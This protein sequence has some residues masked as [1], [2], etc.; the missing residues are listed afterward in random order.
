MS[1]KQAIQ[2]S[3]APA[4]IG[5]YS[6]AIRSGSLLFCSGQIPL[7]PTTMEIVSQDVADQAH[8]VFLNLSAVAESAG[9]SLDAA[10][11]LTIFL[12]DLEDFAVVNE[13]M[14][15]YFKQPYPARA[16]IQVSALPKAAQ[17]EIEAIL[18]L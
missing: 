11:K 4:A 3:N 15:K 6:Q 7:D 10:V 8:Q 14:S 9:S 1:D 16:T 13:I 18:A 12:T 2:T 5:P 17:V